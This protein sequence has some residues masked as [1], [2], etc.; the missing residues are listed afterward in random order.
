MG[1]KSRIKKLKRG[2][3][4][5]NQQNINPEQLP[6]W[7]DAEGLHTIMPGES[8]SEEKLAEMTA[9]YQK[10]IRNSEIFTLMVKQ[11]GKEKAEEMLR[12]FKVEL[13]P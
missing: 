9:D 13:R 1:R 8:P 10:N 12:E 5:N 11:F 2:N 6:V 4:L 3:K 7:Q